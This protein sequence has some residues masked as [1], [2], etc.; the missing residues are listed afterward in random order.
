[1]PKLLMVGARVGRG[2]FQPALVAGSS[3]P[4][5]LKEDFNHPK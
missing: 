5:S 1:M 2:L 3:Q 4:N